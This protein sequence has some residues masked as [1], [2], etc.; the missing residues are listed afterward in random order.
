V[1]FGMQ[2]ERELEVRKLRGTDALRGRHSFRIT[3]AGI[4]VYP[5]IEVLFARPSAYDEW[6]D[7]RC[8][9]GVDQ[10]DAMLGGGIPRGTATLVLGASGAGKTSLGLH[11]LSQS[12]AEEPGL[13]FGFY[14]MPLRLRHKAAG[15]GIKLDDLIEQGHLEILWHPPTEDILD[16]LGNRLLEVV[17]RRGVKRLIVDGLLGLQEIAAD[18]PH[19]IGRFLTALANE[20]RVLKV[21][22]FYTAETRNLIGPIIE[23]PTIGLSTIAENLILLR[24]VE[25]RS[26][27]RRL[28]SVVKMRDSDFD[29]SLREFRITATGIE[30]AQTFDSAEAILS[31]FP[32]L[33]SE[34]LPADTAAKRPRRQ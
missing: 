30:I 2:A 14:E 32:Q 17:R 11:F 24:Y 19:R 4:V 28:I 25:M 34:E 22:T 7:E 1:L 10:L 15:I 13:L 18:R 29:S 3:E 6:P 27:L 12:S 33:K 21:T 31:G 23:G 9:T 8:A 5:R 26:Q 16:A 20:L